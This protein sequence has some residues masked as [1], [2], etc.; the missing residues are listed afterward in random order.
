MTDDEAVIV[1]EGAPIV[2]VGAVVSMMTVKED[3]AVERLPAASVAFAVIV[4][5]PSANALVM[6]E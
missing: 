6:I 5:E 1:A 4:C 2:A 3:E